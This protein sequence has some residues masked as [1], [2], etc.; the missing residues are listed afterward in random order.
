MSTLKGTLKIIYEDV[1]FSI[2]LFWGITFALAI[3][4]TIVGI[5]YDLPNNTGGAIF[6]PLYGG[7]IV[8]C[9]MV[10]TSSFQSA[11]AFGSTRL[12]FLKVYCFVGLLFTVLSIMVLNLLYLLLMI[13]YDQGF[14]SANFLHPGML[15]SQEYSF[16]AYLWI[17]LMIGFTLIGITFLTT[18]IWYKYGFLT[19]VI[20]ATVVTTAATF[21]FMFSE[22][23]SLIGG[24]FTKNSFTIF[25][26]LGLIGIGCMFL[27]YIS[28]QHAPLS[29][30]SK[31][32]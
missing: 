20:I 21:L 32:G 7:I 10:F 22:V 30:K 14:S 13:L 24:M 12:Q 25:P 6:G 28:M 23:G 3:V 16:F 19:I 11:I 31:N 27:S 4:W 17:D 8:F 5:T 2:I 18:S 9:S 29:Y 1:K 26:S 15:A